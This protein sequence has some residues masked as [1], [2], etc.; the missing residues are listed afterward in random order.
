ML[1]PLSTKLITD[2]LAMEDYG[3]VK[4]DDSQFD[5]GW[6][7]S[8]MRI[9]NYCQYIFITLLLFRSFKFIPVIC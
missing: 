2:E 7:I 4:I 5:Y 1:V 9:V 8:D 3:N 6:F